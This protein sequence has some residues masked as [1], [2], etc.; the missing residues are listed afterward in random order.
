MYRY[1]TTPIR[2]PFGNDMYLLVRVPRPEPCDV[3]SPHSKTIDRWIDS[4][5]YHV[6]DPT[7]DEGVPYRSLD[8]LL[9]ED[10]VE[11]TLKVVKKE[12]KVEGPFKDPDAFALTLCVRIPP[13]AGFLAFYQHSP[14]VTIDTYT[15]MSTDRQAPHWI[16]T[17]GNELKFWQQRCLMIEL[18]LHFLDAFPQCSRVPHK[19]QAWCQGVS[20]LAVGDLTSIRSRKVA[21]AC[22][23]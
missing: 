8:Y 7:Q 10:H 13:S 1:S 20:V 12:E 14:M 3:H 15:G 2:Q 21:V 19:V 11:C 4:A 18:L 16:G 22:S 6:H 17:V 23:P 5:K 9:W